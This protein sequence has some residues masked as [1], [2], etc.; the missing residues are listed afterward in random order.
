MINEEVQRVLDAI[1]A[2]GQSGDATERAQKL[3]GLLDEWSKRHARIRELRQE[4]VQ[5]MHASGM[6]Y[7]AIG[8]VLGISFSRARH[9]A[10]GITNPRAVKPSKKV[11]DASAE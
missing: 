10:Q 3:T 5:E 11:D 6:S 4:A 9:I 7:R 2:L 1:D 8:T